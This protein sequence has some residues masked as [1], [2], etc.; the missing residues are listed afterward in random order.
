MRL[1]D[2]IRLYMEPILQAWENFART[3]EPPALS[4]D[5]KALRNH[6]S[7]M[8]AAI[9]NDLESTQTQ[10]EEIK[11]SEGRGAR[12]TE[13]TAA[14]THGIARLISGYSMDQLASEYRALRSSV[15]RLW[16]AESKAGLQTDADDITRFNEAIDQSLGESIA[17]YSKLF[18]Q[19]QSLFLAILGHD[20][21]TP[22]GA[23]INGAQILMLSDDIEP[24]HRDIVTRIHN[25]GRRMSKLVD[26]LIDYT[27]TQLGSGLPIVPKLSNI[28]DIARS[29][30][31]EIRTFHQERKIRFDAVGKLDGIWDEDRIAQVISNILGNAIQHGASE[32][33]IAVAIHSDDTDVIVTI[34]NQGPVIPE[35]K[36]QTIFEP[37][38]RGVVHGA[39]NTGNEN[40]LGLGLHIAREI[41]KAHGGTV[42][43]CSSLND[44]TTFTIRLPRIPISIN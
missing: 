25:S 33:A 1:S 38:V 35:E 24:R 4:M 37:L 31:D 34:N 28:T 36:L 13:D 19:S 3:I 16:A 11:K 32:K 30:I 8:L 40:S 9:A 6:A 18:D 12:S 15:L 27:R 7:L 43:V 17:R 5:V 23:T 41:V 39:A 20:L 2:F 26:D 29:V 10:E 22:I 21:R 14:E 44:G 42:N